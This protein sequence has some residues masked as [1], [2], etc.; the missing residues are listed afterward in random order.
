MNTNG[1]TAQPSE[2]FSDVKPGGKVFWR[3]RDLQSNRFVMLTD[4]GLLVKTNADVSRDVFV[5]SLREQ[6]PVAGV[7]VAMISRNG[8]TLAEAVTD[9]M[10]RAALPKPKVT[11]KEMQAVALVARRGSD[12][13]FIPL[14]PG[15]L[16]AVDYSRYDIDGIL[17]S[18]AQAVEAH[19]FTERG[20]YRPGDSVQFAAIVKRRDWQSVIEGL[21]VRA[22]LSD[23]E[24]NEIATK[25]SNCPPMAWSM[26]A[27]R[28]RRRIPL[29]SMNFVSGC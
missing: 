11:A 13:S 4:L 28:P 12:L 21:P 5:M 26:A 22:T 18:R 1:S 19:I 6:K 25:I 9:A 23:S 24:G 20:V 14:R 29:A 3:S 7:L 2:W 15:Q 8:S 17:H 10:G 16:P 27:S